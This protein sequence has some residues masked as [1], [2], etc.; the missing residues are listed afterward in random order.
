[1]M[2]D[3]ADENCLSNLRCHANPDN[4]YL[5]I[6]KRAEM[7]ENKGKLWV[8]CEGVKNLVS[9]ENEIL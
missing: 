4:A 3:A 7:P 5:R 9:T 6:I 1:M 8:A 2:N